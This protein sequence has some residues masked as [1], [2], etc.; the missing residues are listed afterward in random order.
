MRNRT[1]ERVGRPHDAA[2]RLDALAVTG[3]PRQAAAGRP[4]PVA[5]HDDRDVLGN[6]LGADGF[7][8]RLLAVARGHTMVISRNAQNDKISCSFF[9]SS[10]STLAM[11]RS[12]VFWI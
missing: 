9:L 11:N 10:S 6:G 12:V 1:P 3:D 4:S 2:R 5:V 8:Q 7:E